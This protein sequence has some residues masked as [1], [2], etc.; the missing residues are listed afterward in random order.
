[1]KKYPLYYSPCT[2]YPPRRIPIAIADNVQTEL[3]RMVEL[4]VIIKQE[5]TLWVNSRTIVRKSGKIKVSLDP[6]KLNKAILH[7]PYPLR[8]V[9]GVANIYG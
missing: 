9:E 2:Y 1:M 6:T 3:Q 8:T 5:P 7:G 4:G